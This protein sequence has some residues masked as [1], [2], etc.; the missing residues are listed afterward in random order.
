MAAGEGIPSETWLEV[1]LNGPWGPDLQPG[2]PVSVE[3]II[4]EGIE[5]AEAGA[6]IIHFHAY[7]EATGRQRD[8]WDIYAR[9][10]EGIRSRVDIIA[11]PTIPLAGSGLGSY[12]PSAAADRYRH[13]EELAR[14]GLIEWTVCDPGTVNFTRFDRIGEGDRGFVYLNPGEHIREGLRIAAAHQ[15]RPSY[16]IYEP[17][18]ARLGAGLAT[19]DIPTP[20]YRLMFSDEFAWGFP[21][22][23]YAL[24]AYLALLA[25]VAPGAPWMIA[26]L[27][28][29][30]DPLIEATLARGGHLRVG[31]E[32]APLGSGS[33]N[34]VLAEEA[35]RHMRRLGQ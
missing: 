4:R 20:I 29:H 24:E 3:A 9:I 6:A 23:D 31:L 13:V 7:D 12:E 28:V 5:V 17:G 22:K 14:R 11:Y 21:P 18:F 34:L 8:D 25:E 30:V 27:G 35:V 2:A 26:G 32:D 10:I 33:S 15:I 16:A 1:A 19:D